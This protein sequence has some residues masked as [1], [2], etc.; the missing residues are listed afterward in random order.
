MSAANGCMKKG[1]RILSDPKNI[2]MSNDVAWSRDTQQRIEELV[3]EFL[4]D[5]KY[6]VN[7]VHKNH[8]QILKDDL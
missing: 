6:A 5:P 3:N 8:V 7:R 4:S 2:I 1:L